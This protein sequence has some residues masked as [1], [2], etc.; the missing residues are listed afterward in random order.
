[1]FPLLSHSHIFRALRQ[2]SRREHALEDRQA[3]V[4]LETHALARQARERDTQ[5]HPSWPSIT[6]EP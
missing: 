5:T 2:L 6:Q 3:G 1:M 4:S